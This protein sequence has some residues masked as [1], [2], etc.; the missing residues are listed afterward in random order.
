VR[1][2]ARQLARGVAAVRVGEGAE[3]AVLGGDARDA[4]GVGPGRLDAVHVELVGYRVRVRVRVGLGFG[5]RFGFGFGFGFGLPLTLTLILTLP[6][7]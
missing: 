4:R 6:L 2:R 5:F 3:D 7:P 1:V